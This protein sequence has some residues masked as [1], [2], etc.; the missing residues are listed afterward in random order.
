[1]STGGTPNV[2]QIWERFRVRPAP[3]TAPTVTLAQTAWSGWGNDPNVWVKYP[4]GYSVLDWSPSDTTVRRVSSLPWE[5]GRPLPC[6]VW[7]ESGAVS[8][9]SLDPNMVTGTLGEPTGDTCP[10]T[11]D[12]G[13][14]PTLVPSSDQK[15]S[16]LGGPYLAAAY[17]W[18]FPV[19][20][21]ESALAPLTVLAR[22]VPPAMT[23]TITVT[24]P[25]GPTG[26]TERTIYRFAY[27]LDALGHNVG[28]TWRYRSPW[29]L[30]TEMFGAVYDR[31]VS[32]VGSISDNVTTEWADEQTTL[33]FSGTRPPQPFIPAGSGITMDTTRRVFALPP[34]NL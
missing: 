2:P 29:D 12:S 26:T 33:S 10:I 21:V 27:D 8:H 13:T 1:L 31:M 24:V 23:Y 9:W 7:Q 32:A 15:V 30:R 20:G 19:D 3:D 16:L 6:A 18:T 4:S 5:H 11:F 22:L 28:S 34:V 14:W 25:L 17:G